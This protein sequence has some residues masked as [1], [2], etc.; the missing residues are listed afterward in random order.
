MEDSQPQLEAAGRGLRATRQ[1]RESEIGSGSEKQEPGH[2][3]RIS[4]SQQHEMLLAFFR[5]L[6]KAESF[7]FGVS[8]AVCYGECGCLGSGAAR[9]LL[10][11]CGVERGKMKQG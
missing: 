4:F 3:G 5:R 1:E 6:G 2:P 9:D 7:G 10:R 11:V 8:E